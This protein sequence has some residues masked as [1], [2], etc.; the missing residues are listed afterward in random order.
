LLHIMYFSSLLEATTQCCVFFFLVFCCC[1]LC[2]S[3][4]NLKLFFTKLF[5][6][7]LLFLVL[8]PHCVIIFLFFISCPHHVL[9]FSV[10]LKEIF[11]FMIP[12]MINFV[13]ILDIIWLKG[14]Q[15]WQ[16]SC[17]RQETIECSTWHFSSYSH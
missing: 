16:T 4:F 10:S 3:L 2:F 14:F 17:L 6:P 5:F 13:I 7:F 8:S 11:I 12:Y 1:L 9:F 15:L